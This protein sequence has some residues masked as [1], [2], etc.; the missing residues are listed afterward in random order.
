MNRDYNGFVHLHLHT[1]YS[2]LD[3]V[4]KL[5]EY[6][7]RAKELGME[8]MAVTDHGN[9]FCAAEFYK[10]AIK[11]GI[12]PII[13]M[14][15]YL[16]EGDAEEK[17]S[18]I[19]HLVLLVKNETGYKNLV[20][21]SSYAYTKGFYYK[22]RIDKKMLKKHSEGLIA[23]S[24]C[25]KGE[26][27]QYIIQGE[28]EK[29]KDSL[30]EYLEI[31]DKDD[32]YIEIQANGIVEQ[33]ILNEKLYK[34]AEEN[35]VKTVATN[36][37]HY[38]HQGDD[39][40]Q[41]IMICLQTGAK[42][43][44]INRM[45]ID[46][47]ELY[48]KSK[49]Q[50]L[51]KLNKYND[52]ILNTVEIARKCNLNMEFGV[53]KFPDYKIPENEKSIE[54]Y[55][56]TLVYQGIIKRYK[57]IENKDIINRVEYELGII[58]KMGYAGYFI[59]VWDFVKYAKDNG[60]PVGPGRGSAAGSIVSYLLDITT[61]DPIK[62]N[63]IF[64]RFLNP[65]RIS[66]PDIDIDIC[67]ERRQEVIKYV[68]EKYGQERV[69]QI[70]TFGTLKARAAV[71]DVGRVLGIALNKI[72]KTAKLIPAKD[73]LETALKDVAELREMYT[74]DPEIQK[75]IEYS[76][77]LEGKVRHASIHA[78]GVV[79]SKNPLDEEVPLYA[80]NKTSVVSTQ[81]Q[82]KE[83]EEIGLLKMDF[84]GLKN[85]SILK[86]AV[87]YIKQNRNI[88]IDLDEINID[89]ENTYRLFQ[90]GDTY[91]VFQLESDGIKKLL[92]RMIPDKFEDIIAILALYR[93]GPLGSGM[94]DDYINVKHNKIPAKYMHP[95]LEDVLKETY[96]VILYQEQVMK[97]AN[98]MANYSLGEADLLR[99][100]MGKKNF[101]IMEE[102]KNK[103]IERSIKNGVKEEIAAEIFS[104]I[105]KFAGYG[106]NKS[107]SA[108]YALIAYWT[109]YLK[110]NYSVEYFAALMSSENNNMDKLAVYIDEAKKNKIEVLLPDVNYSYSEFK[111]EE[112]KIRFGISAIKNLG[113]NMALA[114]VKERERKGQY[115]TYEE[116]VYRMKKQGLNRKHLEAFIMAGALDSIDGNRKQKYEMIDNVLEIALKKIEKENDI[117]QT[118]FSEMKSMVLEFNFPNIDDF[119]KDE[120]LKGEKEYLGLYFSGHPMDK[121]KMKLE[122]FK[123]DDIIEIEEKMPKK[124][125]I[126]GVV[127]ELNKKVTKSG[128]VMADFKLED[129]KGSIKI[130]VFPNNYM[131]FSYLL[132][133]NA[134][135]FVEGDTS[136]DSFGN[137]EE[138]KIIAKNIKNIDEIEEISNFK[139]Y[140]L[141]DDNNFSKSIELKK[142]LK[143]HLGK[144]QTFLALKKDGKKSIIK[145]DREYWIEPSEAFFEEVEKLLGEG[146][147]AVR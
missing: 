26:I 81:Y 29:A 101:D 123:L 52:A 15:A 12:K 56:R 105:D 104:L 58:N 88:D 9:M 141:L 82:M 143:K 57:T 34:F 59:V 64:E 145:L 111:V 55:L 40:L 33:D 25:M 43:N 50:M 115:K 28:N 113:E 109:A 72:D 108:A 66:M 62:Y 5:D 100:A 126:A 19:Y 142:I 32:F 65:E 87:E 124:V 118:L 97:I 75:V 114:V 54:T 22:P 85:L 1:E 98:V 2:L 71:R 146:T 4:G 27:P 89:D 102:N 63:L 49:E 106:F 6:I 134:L 8:A 48:F 68:I 18:I 117:R 21:L 45:K 122:K 36:D 99:R 135:V 92:M 77:R 112:N 20:K 129:Y 30:K 116:F 127:R 110:A 79:I 96:G 44:D 107:H 78:A 133:E 60:I 70:I 69:S 35:K 139:V 14:E 132:L 125:K 67:Q 86:R 23:L 144:H 137:T 38:V 130:I 76:I 83:L 140:I 90:K 3:G 73:D 80:D 24:A 17:S 31:F 131:E 95:M 120:K 13:G 93:P 10:K 37:V 128:Q 39:V 94:V 74:K 119:S 47:D 16:S 46:T 61:L 91:G 11:K 121:Y 51:Q 138:V 42:I 41:D 136:I 53:F 147:I 84:L 103:F 7:D